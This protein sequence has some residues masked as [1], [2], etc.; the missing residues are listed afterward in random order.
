MISEI[1]SVLL[2]V[3]LIPT[4]ICIYKSRIKLKKIA[5][6]LTA[7]FVVC[8]IVLLSLFPIDNLLRSFPTPEEAVSYQNKE[9]I[10]DVIL[11]VCGE[12]SCVLQTLK[13]NYH[14]FLAKKDEEGWDY[15]HHTSRKVLYRDFLEKDKYVVVYHINGTDDNYV[16]VSHSSVG[17]IILSDNNNTDF[18]SYI[19]ENFSIYVGYVKGMDE[20]YKITINGKEINLGEYMDW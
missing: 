1:I 8:V 20:D 14:I 16:I 7:L 19:D 12:D 3:L 2:L 6:A 11:K 9:D 17:E 18:Q 10:G 5:V 15:C 4:G 13:G